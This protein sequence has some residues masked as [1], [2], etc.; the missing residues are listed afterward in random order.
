M[1]TLKAFQNNIKQYQLESAR[2]LKCVGN[3]GTDKKACVRHQNLAAKAKAD[4]EKI[5]EALKAKGNT[6]IQ[7]ILR[8][9]QQLSPAVAGGTQLSRPTSGGSPSV[10]PPPPGGATF[11]PATQEDFDAVNDAS[12]SSVIPIVGGLLVLGILGAAAYGYSRS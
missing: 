5:A 8:G 2:Y 6:P 7:A 12:T 4:A 1:A 11:V 3:K 10:L 9:L